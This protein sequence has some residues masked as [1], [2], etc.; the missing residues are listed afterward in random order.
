MNITTSLFD[1][2]QLAEAAYANFIDANGNMI[3]NNAGVRAAL[4][5]KAFS[6]AQASAFVTDWQVIRQYTAPPGLF[7]ITD[8]TGFSG[9]GQLQKFYQRA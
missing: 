4:E 8:G 2:A 6:P 1:Q 3:T 5:S 7:G 9:T